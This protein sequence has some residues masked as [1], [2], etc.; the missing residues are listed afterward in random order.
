MTGTRVLLTL[1]HGRYESLLKLRAEL[2]PLHVAFSGMREIDLL[3]GVLCALRT[4]DDLGS[5]IWEQMLACNALCV[6]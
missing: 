1:Y 5:E 2:D 3:S 4:K 6:K